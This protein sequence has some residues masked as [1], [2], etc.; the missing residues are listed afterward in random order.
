MNNTL[1]AQ[2]LKTKGTQILKERT[3]RFK[4]AVVSVRGKNTY[5]VLTI[6]HYNH[7]REC[8]LEAALAATEKDISEG[9][10]KIKSI[11]DHIKE[12]RHA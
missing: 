12:L 8:E 1:T 7:L 9:N 6:E 4:E 3:K 2:E 5:V 10:F 11:E